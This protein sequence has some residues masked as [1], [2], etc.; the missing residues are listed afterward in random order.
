MVVASLPTIETCP[1]ISLADF[2]QTVRG[3]VI[4]SFSTTTYFNV[5]PSLNVTCALTLLVEADDGIVVVMSWA[6]SSA[7]IVP[8]L[9][10]SMPNVAVIPSGNEM[11]AV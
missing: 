8:S 11:G 7:E 3:F 1:S 10:K 5:V 2:T 4:L 6:I 9:L